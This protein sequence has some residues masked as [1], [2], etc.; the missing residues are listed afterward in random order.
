MCKSGCIQCIQGGNPCTQSG[1][2][3]L[4]Y[5]ERYAVYPGWYAVYSEWYSVYS[6][7]CTLCTH[8]GAY[9]NQGVTL[10]TQDS[11]VPLCSP[12]GGTSA[13][14]GRATFSKMF[15][16]VWR[17]D[18]R[19]ALT[20]GARAS[21]D[22]I[23]LCD[24]SRLRREARCCR[25]LREATRLWEMSRDWRLMRV[26]RGRRERIWFLLRSKRFRLDRPEHDGQGHTVHQCTR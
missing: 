5:S 12:E 26:P 25:P 23:A 6:Q 18:R 24:T 7:S 11:T 19:G 13:G 20:A 21:S 14:G 2:H 10:G 3:I 16:A 8:S 4:A 1:P 17:Q 22:A 15:P 9:C